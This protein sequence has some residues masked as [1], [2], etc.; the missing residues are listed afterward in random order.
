MAALVSTVPIYWIATYGVARLG[1][2]VSGVVSGSAFALSTL[3]SYS[4]IDWQ[5]LGQLHC[6]LR[7]TCGG[8]GLGAIVFPS[9]VGD[10]LQSLLVGAVFVALFSLILA[11]NY[12][13]LALTLTVA[14]IFAILVGFFL[15]VNTVPAPL[16]S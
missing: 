16:G 10:F 15:F 8:V 6:Y 2:H 13:A 14:L 1:W 3:G 11:R 9:F 4:Y 7:G 5:T 12:K